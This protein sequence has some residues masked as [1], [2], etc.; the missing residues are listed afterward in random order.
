MS[1]LSLLLRPAAHE[2]RLVSEVLV[3]YF[4]LGGGGAA[5]AVTGS[6]AFASG[7]PVVASVGTAPSIGGNTSEINDTKLD[8]ITAAG[9][10]LATIRN[11]YM[12]VS[13]SGSPEYDG[14]YFEDGTLGTYDFAN[15]AGFSPPKYSQRDGSA[16]IYLRDGLSWVLGTTF[17]DAYTFN[18]LTMDENGISIYQ[19]FSPLGFVAGGNSPAPS[20]SYYPPQT[21]PDLNSGLIALTYPS[22]IPA[23]TVSGGLTFTETAVGNNRQYEFTAG[24]GT[25]TFP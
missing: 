19:S 14:Y 17:F 4:L 6:R 1:L 3:N 15:A 8:D 22:A 10:S 16:I 11:G 25:I 20:V 5:V 9:S 18:S 21:D 24:S 13:G 12:I 2:R 23:L 7:V